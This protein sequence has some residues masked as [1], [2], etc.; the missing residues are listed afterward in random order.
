MLGES[1][2]ITNKANT[3]TIK[4]AGGAV[5]TVLKANQTAGED[6]VSGARLQLPRGR[7]APPSTQEGPPRVL[8]RCPD[9]CPALTLLPPPPPPTFR[10]PPQKLNNGA[11]LHRIDTLLVPSDKNL[12]NAAKAAA[13]APASSPAK[14][15][16]GAAG[17][18]AGNG[19]SKAAAPAAALLAVAIAMLLA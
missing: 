18:K 19:A 11:V 17:V 2:N 5:A 9:C 13:S 10:A 6:I 12:L 3:V 14:G 16:A 7:A 15:P 1:I 4:S 8:G